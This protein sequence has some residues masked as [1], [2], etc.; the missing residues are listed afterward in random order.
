MFVN[1]IMS[2]SWPLSPS[3]L[4][5]AKLVSTQIKNPLKI[6][7][8]GIFDLQ[9]TEKQSYVFYVYILLDSLM[10]KY[11]LLFFD[12]SISFPKLSLK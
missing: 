11:L 12:L 3:E 6:N 5:W 4:T 7:F 2:K 9:I 8:E 1:L 10:L